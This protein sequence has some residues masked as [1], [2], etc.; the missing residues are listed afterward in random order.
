VQTFGARWSWWSWWSRLALLAIG[1]GI[2]ARADAQSAQQQRDVAL[3]ESYAE[4]AFE[5]YERR[6]Y[7][8]AVELYEQAY[9]AAPSADA[10]YNIA[11]V[12]DVGLRDRPLAITYYRRYLSDPGAHPERIGR[13]SQRLT[14]LREAEASELAATLPARPSPPA[15]TPPAP[16]PV[17]VPR[18]P[19]STHAE[20]GRS[21]LQVAAVVTGTVGLLGA[22]VGAA[23]GLSV[24]ADAET[25]DTY[26]EGNRCSSQRGVDVA[27]SASKKA[28]VATLGV[29]VGAGL[30]V[31]GIALWLLDPGTSREP[32]RASSLRLTPVA[33][34]SKLG[35]ELSGAWY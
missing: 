31:T 29:S 21:A 12:Y 6:D 13:A 1:V 32:D 7:A 30:M 33:G 17:E 4:Q 8:Q 23:F 26:C 3:A 25:V 24:L 27:Q 28:L 20:P 15:A 19:S 16:S 10:L 22:G 35:M 9:E 18:S 2:A 5:A 34:R 11:R 14:Q